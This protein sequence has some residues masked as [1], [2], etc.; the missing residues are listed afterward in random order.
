ML[1][2]SRGLLRMLIPP[3]LTMMM[4]LSGGCAAITNYFGLKDIP[5]VELMAAYTNSESEFISVNGMKVHVRDEGE[6]PVL[7]L[8][9]GVMSSLHTW[10]GWVPVLSQDYRVIRMDLPGFGLTGLPA[11]GSAAFDLDLVKDT[12]LKVLENR[13]VTS[14]TFIGNSFGGYISW[15][16]AVE[17][18][19]LVERVV[20]IDAKSFPQKWPWLLKMMTRFPLRQLAP[21]TTPRYSVAIGIYQVYG[22]DGRVAPGIIDRYHQL[23]LREGN[24]KAMIEVL[25]WVQSTEKPFGSEPEA[26]IYDIRQPLMT[27]WGGKDTW[28][29]YDPIGKQWQAAYPGATHAV[30]PDAGHVPMEEIPAQTLT[31]LL[32]FLQST[33]PEPASMRR[34]R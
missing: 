3:A 29:P 13:K 9:H 18:P 7:V 11:E 22:D 12:V 6:G 15:R 14:A 4:L 30:Y 32:T 25:D 31:D 8:L 27:M 20:L 23:L 17:R 5:T 2:F 28:I 19:D 21:I 34:G 16:M 26:G 24:R 1:R 10:D 33:D